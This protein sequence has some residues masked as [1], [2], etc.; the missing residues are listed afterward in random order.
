MAQRDLMFGDGAAYERLMG[1]WSQRVGTRF[2]DWL[3]PRPG[4]HWLDVGAGNGAFTEVLATRAAPARMTGIDPS[5]AQIAYAR[6]RPSLAGSTFHIGDAQALP[7]DDAAFDA[8]TMAL[9]ISFVPEPVRA[10]A[11]M[12]RVTKPGGSVSTYMWDL[13]GG[14]LPL[15][16]LFRALN[17]IGKSG[18]MPPSAEVSR[19]EALHDL[20][21]SAGL[22]EVETDVID[23]DVEFGDFDDFWTSVT[24]GVGPQ[25]RSVADLT[26]DEQQR[27]QTHLRASLPTAA[28]GTIRYTATANAV[29]GRRPG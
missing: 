18:T 21:H 22:A 27:L 26:K 8:S 13:P 28:D 9:A 25:A 12:V 20:W 16:P 6:Q 15:A 29:K 24:L 11:E 10:A 2:V 7:Y 4:L 19:R 23:I 1:R 5:E 14:G 3:A 17:A